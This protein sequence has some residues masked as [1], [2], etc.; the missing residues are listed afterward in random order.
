LRNG[1]GYSQE[2]LADA[3]QLSLRTIQRIENGETEARGDT[4]KRLAKA[5]GVDIAELI[6]IE[7]PASNNGYIAL[8]NIAGVGCLFM[9]IPLFGLI[10]PLALWLNKKDKQPDI[11]AAGKKIVNFQITWLVMFLLYIVLAIVVTPNLARGFTPDMG[12]LTWSELALVSMVIFPLFNV[13]MIGINTVRILKHGE[14][15]YWPSYQFLK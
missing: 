4:L 7:R 10:F 2:Y 12:L 13:V 6:G 15:K 8:M 1:K 14:I 3:A 5:L 9:Y 11:D